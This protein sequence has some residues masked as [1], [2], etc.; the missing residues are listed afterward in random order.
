VLWLCHG[1]GDW[2]GTWQRLFEAPALRDWELIAADLPGFGQS[3]TPP[4]LAMG[5]EELAGRFKRLIEVL[6]PDR[7]VV[8]VGHSLGGVIVTLTAEQEPAWLAG[9]VN[10]EGNLTEADCFLSGAAASATDPDT[11]F[12]RFM[13]T[14][15][16]EGATE[17]AL[18]C[19]AEG[20]ARASLR[21]F[22][23]CSRD[24]V[25]LCVDDQLGRRYQALNIP[26]LYCHGGSLSEE[27]KTMLKDAAEDV[28]QFPGAG[29][30]VQHDAGSAL[31]HTIAR[32]LA[33][34]KW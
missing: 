27:S 5:V 11:W 32:W 26:K 4:G 1:L 8:L 7:H 29:H 30:W 9:V 20:L 12:Q 6:T 33:E 34:H 3:V 21:A 2:S 23:T 22:V 24:L 28:A 18:R 25:R 13:D 10:V 15:N 14:V 31:S 19:Y 16:E 17:P